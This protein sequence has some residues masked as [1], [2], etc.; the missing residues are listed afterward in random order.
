MVS[1]FDRNGKKQ[2]KEF[3]GRIAQ[4]IQHEVDHCNGILI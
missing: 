3:N 1:Y 4:I 2:I